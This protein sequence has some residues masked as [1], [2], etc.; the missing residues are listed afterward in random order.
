[1]D[2]SHFIN[3]LGVKYIYKTYKFYT[4]AEND[5]KT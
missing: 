2:Q 5:E 3:F 1:M 4:K